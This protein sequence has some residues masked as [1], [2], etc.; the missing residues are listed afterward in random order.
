MK[1]QINK[2]LYKRHLQVANQ[3]KDIWEYIEENINEKLNKG[4]YN[5]HCKQ[6]KRTK[7]H[8]RVKNLA[9][10]KFKEDEYKLLNKGMQYNLHFKIK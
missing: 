2:E 8:T 6:Q 10:I 5:T 4:M 3:W 1:Q 7:F 9:T